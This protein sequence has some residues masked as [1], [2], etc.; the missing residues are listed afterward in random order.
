MVLSSPQLLQ[1][2]G[3]LSTV[4][5]LAEQEELSL[6]EGALNGQ[7]EEVI[8]TDDG[9]PLFQAPVQNQGPEGG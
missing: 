5:G 8:V 7:E 9:K 3:Q 2:N 4:N 1:K 6:Q